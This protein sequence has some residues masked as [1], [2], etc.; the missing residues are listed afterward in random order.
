MKV[1]LIED[2]DKLGSMGD[3]VDVK[4]GYARNFLF[5]RDLG[6]LASSS[7]LK[8]V[9]DIKKKKE[10]ALLKE[11]KAVEELKE[12]ISLASCTVSAEAGEDDRLFGSVTAQDVSEAFEAEGF[13]IDKRKIVLNEPIKKLGVY[14]VTSGCSFIDT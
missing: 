13:S 1:I 3:I 5:P 6:K 4:D 11:K 2:V 10:L 8:I 14:H 7:N 12:K 9:E